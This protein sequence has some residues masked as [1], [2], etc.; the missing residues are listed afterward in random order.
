LAVKGK[1]RVDR[2]TK[3]LLWRL[4]SGEI[5]VISHQDLDSLAARQLVEAGARAVVNADCS[6]TGTFP[7]EGAIFLLR[8]GI[9]LIDNVGSAILDLV[10]EGDE[11]IIA[12]RTVYR[13]GIPLACG[14]RPHAALLEE[15]LT[16]ANQRFAGVLNGFVDNTIHHALLE[17]K[18]IMDRVEPPPIA[19]RLAGRPAVVVV[20]GRGY[21]ED[22][23]ALVPYIRVNRPALIAVD[24]A[25]D[26]LLELGLQPD[27]IFGDMDSVSDRGLLA[28]CRLLVHGYPDGRAPGGGRLQELGLTPAV[29]ACP[30]TSEDAALLL[31]HSAGAA[32]V[33]LVGS[34]S[35]PL[36]FLEKGRAGMASTLLVRLKLGHVLIDAQG[37]HKLSSPRKDFRQTVRTGA[38]AG[39]PAGLV[40]P[41]RHFWHLLLL[42]LRSRVA[43]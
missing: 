26:L 22:L 5:A 4:E 38:P 29:F 35:T 18:A 21:R 42:Q 7:G 36:D 3:R 23:A 16:V 32:P 27:L 8:K 13:G 2:C 25:A 33:V 34:H 9:P 19:V 30:G 41:V 11:L 28:G 17:M 6:F 39:Y 10:R 43:G 20:R 37:L 15:R 40:A 24:G 12:G 1:A 14:E 31:A